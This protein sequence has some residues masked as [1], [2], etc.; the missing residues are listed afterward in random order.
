M[1]DDRRTRNRHPGLTDEL[2]RIIAAYADHVDHASHVK[3]CQPAAVELS[4][5]P[6][7][8]NPRWAGNNGKVCYP[9]EV[10]ADAAAKAVNSLPGADRVISYRC[11]RGD[12]WH[13]VAAARRA[14][15]TMT[16][17]EKI[18]QAAQRAANR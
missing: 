11:P 5:Y 13:H 17:V 16:I 12:H 7:P 10:N 2:R 6:S 3:I 15:T 14:R 1:I 8:G 18:A 4:F 9:S